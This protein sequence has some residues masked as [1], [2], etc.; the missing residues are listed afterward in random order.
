[1]ILL[2]TT[3]TRI[4]SLIRKNETHASLI[5]KRL[6]TP[7]T[8]V[9]Y[10]LRRLMN[11]GR[12]E[13]RIDGRKVLWRLSKRR[14][15]NKELIREFS[16]TGYYECYK[17]LFTLKKEESLYVLQGIEAGRAEFK[18]IPHYL[19]EDIHR[20]YKR[21]KII[22]HSVIN[23]KILSVFDE[24]TEHM[25]TS[26]RGRVQ[27]VRAV[28]SLFTSCGE[29]FVSKSFILIVNPQKKRGLLIKEGDIVSLI[30]DFMK[31]FFTFSDQLENIDLNRQLAQKTP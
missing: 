26:H 29:C 25:R 10:R 24:I 8:S 27:N 7:R 12:I 5:A 4:L 31:L 17:I 22:M 14:E 16:G 2:D 28:D 19:I 3:D 6:D 15:H 9:A 23:K 13:S 30:S 21:K 1:M 18:T 20:H 11:F